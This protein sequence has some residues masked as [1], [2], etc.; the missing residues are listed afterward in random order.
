MNTDFIVDYTSIRETKLAINAQGNA[1]NEILC[2]IQNDIIRLAEL[3]SFQGKTA[4]AIKGYF[5]ELY[6]VIIT[7]I[8]QII[9]AMMASLCLLGQRLRRKIR[10][11]Y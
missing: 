11:R 1:Y 8:Q 9:S 7:G 2:D 6:P 4:T 10:R 3:N 5:T